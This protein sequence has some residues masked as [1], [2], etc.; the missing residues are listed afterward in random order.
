[1]RRADGVARGGGQGASRCECRGLVTPWDHAVGR[2]RGVTQS[3][4]VVNGTCSTTGYHRV[5]GRD[6][7]QQRTVLLATGDAAQAKRTARFRWSAQWISASTQGDGTTYPAGAFP[8]YSPVSGV[9]G[10]TPRQLG[11]CEQ[12]DQDSDAIILA[13][14]TGAHRRGDV[15]AG[16]GDGGAHPH[17]R[18]RDDGAVGGAGGPVAVVDRGGGGRARHGR[19]DRAGERRPG[20]GAA[21]GVHCGLVAGAA[22]QLDADVRRVP[23]RPHVLRADRQGNRP[24]RRRADLLRRGLLLRARRHRLRVPRPRPARGPRDRPIPSASWPAGVRR[25]CS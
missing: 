5:W 21:V 15:R 9:Q 24:G 23:G 2:R 6:Q 8:R 1:M 25:R 7:Y 10:A 12:L 22:R 20:G 17:E 14:M 3:G 11:W 18:A 13:G 19:G 16:Q 4:D